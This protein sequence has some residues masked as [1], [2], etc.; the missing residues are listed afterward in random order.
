MRLVEAARKVGIIDAGRGCEEVTANV[1]LQ[2]RRRE[3]DPVRI[4]RRV[5][6]DGVPLLPLE[7]LQVPVAV[8]LQ[9][10]HA[11]GKVGVAT[12]AREDRDAVATRDSVAHQMWSDESRAAQHEQIQ[13]RGRARRPI[14]EHRGPGEHLPCHRRALLLQL[15]ADALRK[16]RRVVPG[17]Q[18]R[19]DRESCVDISTSRAGS[20]KRKSSPE[21]EPLRHKG[22]SAGSRRAIPSALPRRPD[23]RRSRVTPVTS[24]AAPSRY[25]PSTSLIQC[26]PR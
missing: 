17:Q 26:A 16:R 7:R 22:S 20:L 6:D 24:T 1:S 12:A 25:P 2:E 3:T 11:G 13:R 21:G 8:S 18:G 4:G 23:Q 19:W 5:I 9:S 14:P 10:D 15:A